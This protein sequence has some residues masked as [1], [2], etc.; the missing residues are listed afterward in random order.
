M[1]LIQTTPE[2]IYS[3]QLSPS[4]FRGAISPPDL[5][6]S[7]KPGNRAIKDAAQAKNIL[8][9]F[10]Q[11]NRED[12]I[13]NARIQAK[14]NSE[15]PHRTEALEAEGLRWK[16]NFTTQPLPMLVEKVA[17]R[18]VQAVEGVKYLTNSCL[19]DSVPGAS[20]KTEAFRREITTLCRKRP[21]WPDL[22]GDMAQENGLFG[23]N[24]RG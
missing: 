10:L 18:F 20:V 17:P 23:F 12:T 9:T 16:S 6:A 2:P 14:V 21:E 8:Q 3:N 22:V 13:K 11:A 7:M 1:P 5:S 15:K 19:P 24:A 4:D